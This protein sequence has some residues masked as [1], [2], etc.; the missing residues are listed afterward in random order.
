MLDTLTREQSEHLIKLGFP[1]W[2]VQEIKPLDIDLRDWIPN[3]TLIDLLGALPK[4]IKAPEKLYRKDDRTYYLS[5]DWL[6]SKVFAWYG[7]NFDGNGKWVYLD[8]CSESD[9]LI[10][11]L[12]YLAEWC[13]VNDIK[14]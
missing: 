11:A 12:Y 14:L 1:K 9:E 6:N 13:L 5:I 3:I 4:Q 8:N 7:T 2:K 10:E